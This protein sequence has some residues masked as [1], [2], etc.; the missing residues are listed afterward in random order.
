VAGAAFLVADPVQ[1]RQ[2]L[3][4]EAAALGQDRLDHV[5]VAFSKP[6]RLA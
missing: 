6:G 3:G 5:G 2:H 4:G 1:G